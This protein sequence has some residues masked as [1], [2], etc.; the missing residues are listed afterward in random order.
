MLA[1]RLA[2]FLTGAWIAGS[3]CMVMVATQNFRAVDRLLDSPAPEAAERIQTLGGRDAA[4][5][6]L[7]Y[8][9]SELNRFYFA[10]W[11]RA[12]IALGVGL[13]I[14]LWPGGIVDKL[15][16]GAMLVIVLAGRFWLTPEITL[17]G[18]SIDW[19]PQ[20]AANPLRAYFWKLHGIY[21]ASEVAKQLIGL[22]LAVRLLRRTP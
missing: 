20:A 16:C 15:L 7:R 2:M 22:A 5:V 10:M 13:L 12:Q 6:F 14:A 3:L 19:V 8:H 18:R 9:S 4:R 17:V 1:Q 21:S 11:E